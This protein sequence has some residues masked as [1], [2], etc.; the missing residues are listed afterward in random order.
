M[1]Y[2]ESNPPAWYCVH[3]RSRHE[4]KE[5]HLFTDK[6]IPSFFLIWGPGAEGKTGAK[7]SS[8]TSLSGTFLF[9]KT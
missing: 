5:F 1:S 3:T 4:D 9:M 7:K 6:S 8:K 2:P